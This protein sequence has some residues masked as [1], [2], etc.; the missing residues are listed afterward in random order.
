MKA[1]ITKNNK[2]LE[3]KVLPDEF[4]KALN[5]GDNTIAEAYKKWREKDFSDWFTMSELENEWKS[6]TPKYN[7][8]GVFPEAKPYLKMRLG[9]FKK[10][11]KELSLEILGK[12]T[13]IYSFDFKDDFSR[14]FWEEV[15]K[16]FDGERLNNL[17]KEAKKLSFLLNP[18]KRTKNRIT[19]AMIERAKEY[20]F[21]NLIQFNNRGFAKCFAHIE[22]TPSLHLQKNKNKIHCFGCQK[23]WD[24]IS[25]LMETHGL[26]FKQ[27]VLKLQ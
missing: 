27:T 17:K 7:L 15:I 8:L 19:P 22:K 18:P 16:E 1:M 4:E 11:V 20:P 9:F 25:Y 26:D 2:K 6:L 21:D 12:L 10:V 5:S 24:T 3:L 13:K 23:S 14:W